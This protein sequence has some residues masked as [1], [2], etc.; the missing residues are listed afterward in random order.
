[1]EQARPKVR[2]YAV[3][4]RKPPRHRFAVTRWWMTQPVANPLSPVQFPVKQGNNR[5][6]Q[7]FS[8]LLWLYDTQQ[9]RGNVGLF[10]EIPWRR[11]RELFFLIR[12][13]QKGI[14][15]FS[16]PYRETHP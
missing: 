14:R 5:E 12:D 15:D 8:D 1:M 2:R 4:T 10:R 9:G 3:Y 16:D 6:F 7:P 11:N 13:F